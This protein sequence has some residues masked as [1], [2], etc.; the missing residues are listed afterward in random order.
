MWWSRIP[1]LLVAVALLAGCGF[2][3][4]YEGGRKGE[5]ATELA[6]VKIEPIADRSGQILRNRLLDLLTPYGQPAQPQ[7]LLKV[8][9]S[10]GAS[11]LAV[12]KSEFATRA[13]L[14]ITA[15]YELQEPRSRA[16]LYTGTT[17]IT[18]GYNILS[19]EVSTL[20]SEQNVRE[21]VIGQIAEE[22]Q[23]R[24]S[25]YFRL[26]PEQREALRRN[27]GQPR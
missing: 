23:T 8:I 5:A 10:E 18:G 14:Q 17:A 2:H 12:R 3:P 9:L 27:A 4:L 25:A 22:M 11:G 20:A 24:L 19:S 6:S 13:N 21:R 15:Q 26:N 7:Y 1:V 16:I